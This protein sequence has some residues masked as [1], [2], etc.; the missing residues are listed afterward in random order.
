VAPFGIPE[1]TGRSSWTGLL[2]ERIRQQN[3]LQ[4]AGI[5]VGLVYLAPLIASMAWNLVTSRGT[6]GHAI[7]VFF[8]VPLLAVEV[9]AG[10]LLLACLTGTL[11]RFKAA[12]LLQ[13]IRALIVPFYVLD[14]STAWLALTVL[15]PTTAVLLW[16]GGSKA[17][18]E[19]M[20]RAITGEGS[21]P[22][23]RAAE[24]VRGG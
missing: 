24:Q 11:W 14:A 8:G 3:W 13:G 5:S 7:V 19:A 20:A 2:L 17:E 22:A 1:V 4:L 12:A 21:I 23:E 10:V 15:P 6:H 9:F 18:R 16:V